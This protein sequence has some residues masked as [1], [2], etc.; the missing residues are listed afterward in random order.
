MVWY[1]H[2]EYELVVSVLDLAASASPGF[3]EE[4]N[5]LIVMKQGLDVGV[6]H[7]LEQLVVFQSIIE[8]KGAWLLKNGVCHC[9]LDKRL[10]S[11]VERVLQTLVKVDNA[12][13]PEV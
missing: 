12:K 1:Y 3:Q 11:I 13:D 5:Q 9:E 2:V 8:F 10:L 7:W 6:Q 4:L